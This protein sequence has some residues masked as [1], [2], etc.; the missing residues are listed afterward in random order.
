MDLL[1][2]DVPVRLIESEAEHSAALEHM[3][4]LMGS[5][6]A[7]GSDPERLLKTLAVLVRD[8]E[9][10]RYPVAPPEPID[11]IKFRMEQQGLTPRDLVP[12]LGSRS[13]VSEVLSG[14]RPLTLPMI[15][16]V[17]SW[18]WNPGR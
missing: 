3:A 17:T 10:A 8:Y 9:S 14:K 5:D 1:K 6:P 15:K 7:V 12:Y 2:Y 18:A 11:A 13:R 16:K 4:E